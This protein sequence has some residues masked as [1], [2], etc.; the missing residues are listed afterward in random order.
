MSYQQNRLVALADQ[1]IEKLNYELAKDL[2]GL[3]GTYKGGDASKT[4]T[5]LETNGSQRFSGGTLMRKDLVDALMTGR[6]NIAGWGKWYEYFA[7]A[8]AGGLADTGQLMNVS[9][10]GMAFYEDPNVADASV[11]GNEDHAF[12][13]GQDSLAF[14]TWNGFKGEYRKM[15]PEEIKT[16]FI[17]PATGIEMDLY[18]FYTK[19]EAGETEYTSGNWSFRYTLHYGLQTMPADIW[20]PNDPFYGINYA[21]KAIAAQA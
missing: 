10:R 21:F 14:H 13:I 9:G 11:F 7:N 15:H 17:H 16:T 12:I 19:C 18:G 8:D 1:L 4:Y 6:I 20:K 2:P 3:L 5:I